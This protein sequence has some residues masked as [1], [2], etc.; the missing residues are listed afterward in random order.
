[1]TTLSLYLAGCEQTG[2]IYLSSRPQFDLAFLSRH[3]GTLKLN[4]LTPPLPAG[5]AGYLL[6]QLQHI[7]CDKTGLSLEQLRLCCRRLLRM[8]PY[9]CPD[10][11]SDIPADTFDLNS[12]MIMPSNCELQETET[13]LQGRLLTL[14]EI[15]RALGLAPPADRNRVGLILQAL[16]LMEKVVL[17]PA[18]VPVRG[19]LVRCQRC[20]WEGVP[21]LVACRDCGSSSCCHCPDC[22]VMG[23]LSLCEALF[24][25]ID[26]VE[27]KPLAKGKQASWW[28]KT[29]ERLKTWCGAGDLTQPLALRPLFTKAGDGWPPPAGRES[30]TARD[31]VHATGTSVRYRLDV[32]LTPPQQAAVEKL[33]EFD[34]NR[35][36][37]GTCLVWAACGAGKT[38]VSYPVIARAL[39]RGEKVLFAT[40][41]RA[42]V[43]ELAP[44]LERAFGA[45]MVTALYGG[46][47]CR[48]RGTPL[49][50]ATTHQ[51]LR[52]HHWFDL[53]I[54]DEGDAYPYPQSRMLRFGVERARRPEGRMIYLTATPAP[55]MLKGKRVSGQPLVIKIPARPHGFPLP[56]PQFFKIKPYI[57]GCYGLKLHPGLLSLVAKTLRVSG[58]RLLL[59]V[60]TVEQTV[61]VALALK[62][63]AQQSHLPGLTPDDILW[64]H[65]GDRE[66]DRKTAGFLSGVGRVL[67]TTT[68]MERGVTVARVHVL[69]LNADHTAVFDAPAL[70][71]MAGRSGRSPVYPTGRVFYVAASITREMAEAR[72]QIR[73]L[74]SEAERAGY[75]RSDYRQRLKELWAFEDGDVWRE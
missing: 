42:V 23:Q 16:C 21:P 62:Q 61:E 20:G 32:E 66:R 60:P 12:G 30:A 27:R 31:R 59:F 41:R 7:C 35:S 33:L 72:W 68:I 3:Y 67:V 5:I 49:L 34:A 54:L 19:S 10:P 44:R 70:V 58:D 57:T 11:M 45:Q 36:P 9:R 65:A 47:R 75:L 52:F 25:A 2:L 18:L 50:V 28:V 63:A 14:S 51:V 6:Y 38:E 40:P 55:W 53:V 39:N 22:G 4:L 71:Q 26:R 43:Q 24:T 15:T 46:S 37:G 64:C 73:S 1:M 48:Y 8:L 17:L 29:W 74:N 56:E 13:L 69:V